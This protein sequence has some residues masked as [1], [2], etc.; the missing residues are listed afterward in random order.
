MSFYLIWG[1]GSLVYFEI[2]LK[3]EKINVFSSLLFIY[4]LI[5]LGVN[6]KFYWLFIILCLKK[7]FIWIKYYYFCYFLDYD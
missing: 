4:L 2:V 6:R 1:N 3:G 5:F 7:N